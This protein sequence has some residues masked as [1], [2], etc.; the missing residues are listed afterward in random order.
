M[1]FEI[2]DLEIPF[3]MAK[4]TENA[5]PRVNDHNEAGDKLVNELHAEAAQA[6]TNKTYIKRNIR[7]VQ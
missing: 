3:K 2:Y 7:T 5:K 4:F 6:V 1:K